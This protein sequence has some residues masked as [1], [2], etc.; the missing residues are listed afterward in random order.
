MITD[1][2]YVSKNYGVCL[3]KSNLNLMNELLIYLLSI[4]GFSAIAIWLGKLIISKSFD[5]GIE[6]YKTTLSKELEEYKNELSKISLEHQVKFTKLHDERAQKIKILYS[7]VV[8]VE[9]AL[10]HSTTEAQGPEYINDIARDNAAIEKLRELIGQLDYDRIY[11]SINT[12]SK[13]D[14]IIKESW[15]IILQMQKVRRCFSY[16]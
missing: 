16:R 4:S 12:I 11:F 3:K 9:K 15:E 6:R 1:C 2:K 7:K 5:L 14:I 13:F 10:I 8:E